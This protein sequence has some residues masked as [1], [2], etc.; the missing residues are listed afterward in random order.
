MARVLGRPIVTAVM[1]A[2]TL[3]GAWLGHLLLA[4]AVT[5][6][7]AVLGGAVAGVGCGLLVTFTKLAD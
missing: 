4:D 1:I 3:G 5:P 7:R 6:L 2:C